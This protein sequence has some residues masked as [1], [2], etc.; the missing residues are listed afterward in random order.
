MTGFVTIVLGL[1]PAMPLYMAA[2]AALLLVVIS[3]IFMY[4]PRHLSKT[5]VVETGERWHAPSAA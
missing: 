3:V 2:G 5:P 1:M 4:G